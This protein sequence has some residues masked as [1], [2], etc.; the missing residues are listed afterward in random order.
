METI[1]TNENFDSLINGDKP[2]LI[3]FYADWCGPCRMIMPYIA[4]LA[5]TYSDRAVIARCNVDDSPEIAGRYGV[6]NIPT[7][8]FIKDGRVFHQIYRGASSNEQM[9]Q[10][11]SDT[12]TVLAKGGEHDA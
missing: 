3:D 10:K 4:E 5:E 1:L 6:R 2:M 9:Y 7:V 8:L 11:I 12:L